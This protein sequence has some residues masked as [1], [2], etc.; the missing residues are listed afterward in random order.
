MKQATVPFSALTENVFPREEFVRVVFEDFQIVEEDVDEGE[1][2]R[3]ESPVWNESKNEW[4]LEVRNY[5]IVVAFF[6][7]ASRK[8]RETGVPSIT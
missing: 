7:V 5:H 8:P 2:G 1:V 3:V 6:L 4:N